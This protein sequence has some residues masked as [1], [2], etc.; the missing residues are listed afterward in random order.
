MKDRIN[1]DKGLKLTTAD[2]GYTEL[3]VVEKAISVQ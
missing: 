1:L 2:C 3:L